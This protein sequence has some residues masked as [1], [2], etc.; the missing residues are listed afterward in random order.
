MRGCEGRWKHRGPIC[1]EITHH[2]SEYLDDRLPSPTQIRMTLHLAACS[3]CRTYVKQVGFVQQTLALL[4]RQNLAP[5]THDFLR[6]RFTSLHT[7]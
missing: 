1:W 5:I 2:A 7:Q 3:H 6:C 4:P